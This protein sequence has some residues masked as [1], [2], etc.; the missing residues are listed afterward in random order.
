M[1]VEREIDAKFLLECI[2]SYLVFSATIAVIPWS[3]YDMILDLVAFNRATARRHAWVN[4]R[5]EPVFAFYD[6]QSSRG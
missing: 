2:A 3:N 4:V 1:F 5:A 6:W